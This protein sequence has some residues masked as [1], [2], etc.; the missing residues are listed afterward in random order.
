MAVEA[1]ITTPQSFVVNSFGRLAAAPAREQAEGA[2][3]DERCTAGLG[4]C[5][6][7]G[8]ARS[9]DAFH[10]SKIELVW[11]GE[12]ARSVKGEPVRI[13]GFDPVPATPGPGRDLLR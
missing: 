11:P 6:E 13:V 7:I 8:R 9:A 4:H 3:G 10:S 2:G 5:G 12:I 1:G